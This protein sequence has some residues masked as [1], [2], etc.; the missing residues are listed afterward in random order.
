MTEGAIT[1]EIKPLP[2]HS[3]TYR[4]SVFLGD[5]AQDYD[6]KRDALEFDFIS[7]VFFPETPPI[8]VIGQCNLPW[9]WSVEA[10]APLKK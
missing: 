9:Q 10:P 5:A 8:D 7:P 1:A 3:D 6:E 4:A 2:L